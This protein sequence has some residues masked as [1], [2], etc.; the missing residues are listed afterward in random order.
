M[1]LAWMAVAALVAAL[2]L[3]ACSASDMALG[4]AEGHS[5]SLIEQAKRA[6]DLEADLVGVAPCLTG[7]GAYY[8]LTDDRQKMGLKLLC[9]PNAPNVVIDDT[10][11]QRLAPQILTDIVK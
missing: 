2:A 7:I 6:K 9:D 3:S 4:Y 8:R 5:K 10:P 1:K 11:L